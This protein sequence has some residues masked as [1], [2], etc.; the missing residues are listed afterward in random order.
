MTNH[1]HTLYILI[2]TLT[3]VCIIS[4]VLYTCQT[5]TKPL[6]RIVLFPAIIIV[7]QILLYQTA[8][9]DLVVII[10][11][12]RSTIFLVYFVNYLTFLKEV[13]QANKITLVSSM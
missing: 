11:T 6:I 2:M 4:A 5:A 12:C 9:T 1:L 7:L 10:A 8:S 13:N 3:L